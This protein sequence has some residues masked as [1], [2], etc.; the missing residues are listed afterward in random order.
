MLRGKRVLA[1]QLIQSRMLM[2]LAVVAIIIIIMIVVIITIVIMF[3]CCLIFFL[4]H[5][6]SGGDAFLF[7]FLSLSIFLSGIVVLGYT[8][9]LL[10][11]CCFFICVISIAFVLL[12]NFTT[13]S[14]FS[15]HSLK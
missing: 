7:L 1:T 11:C 4:L 2:T 10:L 9:A 8:F 3:Y 13:P 14:L 15:N 5:N 12:C 6:L